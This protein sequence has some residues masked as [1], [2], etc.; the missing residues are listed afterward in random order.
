MKRGNAYS[1]LLMG[2]LLAG[3]P[4][5]GPGQVQKKVLTVQRKMHRLYVPRDKIRP[6][7]QAARIA[8]KPVAA[9]PLAARLRAKLPEVKRLHDHW[10]RLALGTAPV[11]RVRQSLRTRDEE[12]LAR[13]KMRNDRWFEVPGGIS[14]PIER[15]HRG[16]RVRCL[17]YARDNAV[18]RDVLWIG[19]SGGG[20]WKS[21]AGP[22]GSWQ[23]MSDN[24]PGSP[25]VG[26]FLVHGGDSNRILIGTGDYG[27]YGGTGLYRTTDGGET[28][29]AVALDRNPATF[30]RIVADAADGRGDTVLACG[31]DGAGSG[32]IWRSED[33]G[34]TATRVFTGK[35]TD[36]A[37]DPITAS[38]WW[39]AVAG[40]GIF[41]STDGGRS[42]HAIGGNGGTGLT[43]PIGRMALTVCASAPNYLYAI[44]ER[45]GQLGGI[46]R[47]A[48]YGFNWS[49]IET[50]DEISW[51]QGWHACAIGVHPDD[52][53]LLL[54]G[55]GGLQ[56][57]DNATAEP[58]S[59]RYDV[60]GGHSDYTSFLFH[61]PTGRVV[62]GNDG[63][64][65]QYVWSSGT[66]TGD[67]NLHLNA[68][69]IM[70]PNGF[71]ATSW[72]GGRLMAGLQDNGMVL[73]K[74]TVR[75]ALV[76]RGG[77]DGGQAS[78]GA[79][80]PVT[81]YFSS[82]VSYGRNQAGEA[83][84]WTGING[85]L[86]TEWTPT[87]LV[88]PAERGKV[89]TNTN[90][91]VWQKPAGSGSWSRVNEGHPFPAG[92][93]CKQVDVA[94]DADRWVIYAT[95]WGS[96]RLLV[97]DGGD[98]SGEDW[99][100]RTPPLPAGSG[101]RDCLINAEY[102]DSDKAVV[103]YATAGSRPSRAFL[104]EDCGRHW[105]DVTGDLTALLPDANYWKL[106]RHPEDRNRLF[107][108]TDVGIYV[109]V[110]GG[111]NWVRFMN[112]LPEVVNVMDLV[113]AGQETAPPP[114]I[115][116]GGTARRTARPMVGPYRLFIGTYGRGF[117][118]RELIW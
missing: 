31:E 36:L 106:A 87:V 42:F 14:D 107:L 45:D 98:L 97:F 16:G 71:L 113:I 76:N 95:A 51:G 91:Y 112:G 6:A 81:Y 9:L 67:T 108:A 28:W 34:G 15:R 109:S 50:R 17:A 20:L 93:P 84:D 2:I 4:P 58:V 38:N 24:L 27:R 118:Q 110:N 47:S 92:F 96:G 74:P 5:A 82:G 53:D 18:G 29:T 64:C 70:A 103:F 23:P 90:E 75:P 8:A 77:G 56:R 7:A 11:D 85:P 104:S 83:G 100:D 49:L 25:S 116:E 32:G 48:D 89:F 114:T 115:L 40:Q 21:V 65:Y 43:F 12:S 60:D 102:W 44:V 99:T 1:C 72:G 30:F 55:M 69:Q 63:G 52:P 117:W 111:A 33:F 79:A 22:I 13:P 54:A 88:D 41:E 80:Y 61:P 62:I 59:W 94:P 37:Q 68:L 39:A 78:I 105:R 101:S 19:T 46:F 57:S 10:R 86:G 35:V 3:A 66:W 26:A 73:I